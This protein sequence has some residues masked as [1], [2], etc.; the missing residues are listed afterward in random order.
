MERNLGLRFILAWNASGKYWYAPDLPSKPSHGSI[1]HQHIL[2]YVRKSWKNYWGNIDE[3]F[4]RTLWR[5]IVFLHAEF[6]FVANFFR[7]VWLAH[8]SFHT[9]TVHRKWSCE[10]DEIF[11]FHLYKPWHDAFRVIN[12]ITLSLGAYPLNDNTCAYWSVVF[13]AIVASM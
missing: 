5:T 4:L 3:H 9:T 11:F 2:F 6:Q 12:I 10:N 1:Y 13:F 7:C 8:H